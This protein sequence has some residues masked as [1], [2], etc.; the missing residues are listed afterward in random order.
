MFPSSS[1]IFFLCSVSFWLR[2]L[3]CHGHRRPFFIHSMDNVLGSSS[4]YI[5]SPYWLDMPLS[6]RYTAIVVQLIA[7]PCYVAWL[8]WVAAVDPP[9]TGLL[10][11]SGHA[12]CER[13]SLSR[14]G[15]RVA[16]CGAG[17]RPG[18]KIDSGSDSFGGVSATHRVGSL[19]AS[20]RNVSRIRLPSCTTTISHRALGVSNFRRGRHRLERVRHTRSLQK[21]TECGVCVVF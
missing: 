8:V 7:V 9:K 18:R 3:V 16:V 12:A 5:H 14:T 11:S 1:S 17:D 19:Y 20:R 15:R 21:L 6:A 13:G 10:S 4:S 2:K